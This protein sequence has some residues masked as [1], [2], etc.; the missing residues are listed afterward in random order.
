MTNRRL[1][2][3]KIKEVLRL[4]FECNLSEREIARSCQISRTTVTEYLRRATISGLNW[5]EEAA[6]GEVQ[7]IERL[8]PVM[9][10]IKELAS[11]QRPAPD[12]DHIYKELRAYL[13]VIEDRYQVGATVITS[14]CPVNDWH[15]NIGD[16]DIC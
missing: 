15:P 8:F 1:S 7:L 5:A 10:Q 13:E 12:C 6:L 2:M 9:P 11:I 4:R 16:P 14:Q 3:R